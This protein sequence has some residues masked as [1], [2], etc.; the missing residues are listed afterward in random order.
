MKTMKRSGLGVLMAVALTAMPASAQEMDRSCRCVDTDGNEIERCTCFRAP[1]IEGLV[2]QLLPAAGRPR[3]GISIDPSQ[4]AESDAEGARVTDV[5]EGGPADEAGIQPGDVITRVDGV[6]LT[7]STG[8]EPEARFDLDESVPVQRLLAVT[9]E[10]EPGESVEVEYRRD[11]QLQTTIVE[12]QDLSDRW[13]QDVSAWA[14][15][16][17]A[18]RFR[19]Q[20]RSLT[21]GARAWQFRG[22]VPESSEYR[23]R[24]DPRRELRFFGQGGLEGGLYRDGLRLAEVNPGLGAYFGTDEGVLVLDVERSSTLGLEP[25]DVVLRIGSRGV[26]TPDR[27]RRILTSYGQ[28]EDIDFHVLRDGAEITVTGRFRY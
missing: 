20:M 24:V 22:D 21:D 5:M 6:P 23:L 16:W 28:D 4:G 17:E 13:G 8:A 10:L 19:G 12:V 9:R 11:G 27:F 25:G 26:A 1:N 15:G 3:L 18:E 14:P 2:A 7:S